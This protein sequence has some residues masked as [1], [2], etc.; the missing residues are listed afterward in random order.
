M[1]WDPN[2]FN[3]AMAQYGMNPYPSEAG[4]CP[5]RQGAGGMAHLRYSSID[6]QQMNSNRH[7]IRSPENASYQDGATPLVISPHPDAGNIHHPDRGD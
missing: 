7:F 6:N 2:F 4:R 5:S 1:D 3:D